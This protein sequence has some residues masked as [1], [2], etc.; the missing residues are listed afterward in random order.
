MYNPVSFVL[1][2]DKWMEQINK[3]CYERIDRFT[4]GDV[5]IFELNKAICLGYVLAALDA[6]AIIV[7]ITF[8]EDF[9][10]VHLPPNA[11]F[12]CFYVDPARAIRLC[13][14]DEF[15]VRDFMQTKNIDLKGKSK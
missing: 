1:S 5:V 10:S 14:H 8:L 7:C 12:H 2:F 15:D 6:S 13:A 4:F 9:D 11:E 3:N